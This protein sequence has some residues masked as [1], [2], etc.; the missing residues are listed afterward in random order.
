[1]ILLLFSVGLLLVLLPNLAAAISPI[2][3]KGTKLYDQDGNQFFVRG[4]AYSP[5]AGD[6]D[7][8]LDTKQCET[9]AGLMQKAGINTVYV[10][11]VDNEQDHDGCMKAFA[12]HGIYVWL[13][14]GDFPR[15]TKTTQDKP[16]WTLSV[17][18]KWTETLDA[19][20]LYPNILAFGIGQETI[21]EPGVA[22]KV[23]PSLKAAAR[24][25]H[26]FRIARGY[27]PIPLSYSA[28]DIDSL[29]LITAQYLTCDDPSSPSS[30]S[31]SSSASP[32]NRTTSSIDLLGLNLFEDASCSLTTWKSLYQSLR[33]LPLPIPVVLSE[34]GCRPSSD[35]PSSPRTFAEVARA[36]SPTYQDVFSGASVFEWTMH[37]TGFGIAEYAD[38]RGAGEVPSTTA[39]DFEVLASLFGEAAKTATGTPAGEYTPVAR[40]VAAACPTMDEARGWLVPGGAALPVIEGLEVGTVTVKTTVTAATGN[41]GIAATGEVDVGSSGGEGT[42]SGGLSTGAIAGIA[43]GCVL[44][45]ALAVSAAALLCIRRQRRKREAEEDTDLQVVENA[46]YYPPHQRPPSYV[47]PTGKFELPTHAHAATEIGSSQTSLSTAAAAAAG[48]WKFPMMQGQWQG[49]GLGGRDDSPTVMTELPEKAWRRNTQHELEDSSLGTG[50]MELSRIGTGTM[51]TM[52][53]WKVSPV[54]QGNNLYI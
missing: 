6:L 28:A 40:T 27:R 45:A 36:L 34:A 11:T 30:S 16:Q 15:S 44:L 37:D 42:G 48:G 12:N 26:A 39:A 1:M 23:A 52:G 4:V 50:T 21:P 29:R 46:Q 54:S 18:A 3:V 9:D 51:G 43:I 22:T 8:L 38:D 49:Q 41:H 13:Q 25:L 35:D 19:F 5:P 53:T 24:D 33:S 20:A 17:Y 10:Y 7:P 47:Y 32:S 14:L 2:S 31:S